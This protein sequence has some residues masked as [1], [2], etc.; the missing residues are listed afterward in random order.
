MNLVDGGRVGSYLK[1]FGIV[2]V[3][4]LMIVLIW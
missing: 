3:K 4:W 1:L 2:Y